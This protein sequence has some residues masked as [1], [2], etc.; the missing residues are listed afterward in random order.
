MLIHQEVGSQKLHIDLG[1]KSSILWCMAKP[2]DD[3]VRKLFTQIGCVMEDASIVALIWRNGEDLGLRARL[4][5]L[6]DAH[7]EIGDLLEQI[8]KAC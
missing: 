7:V 1:D 8:E 5:R 2:A 3:E 4:Q 6:S